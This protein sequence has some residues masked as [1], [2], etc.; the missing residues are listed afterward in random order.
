LSNPYSGDKSLLTTI[1]QNLIENAIKYS[2]PNVDAI[3]KIL[4]ELPLGGDQ[5][6]INVTDN[7]RGIKKDIQGDVFNMFFRGDHSEAIGS[8]LGLYILKNAVDKL[9]GSVDLTSQQDVGTSFTV[10][11]PLIN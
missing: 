8:G 7:G 3:V 5:L 4:I 2:R 9:K 6:T 1:I 11:I 10:K